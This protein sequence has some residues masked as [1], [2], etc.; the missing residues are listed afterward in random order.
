[1]EWLAKLCVKLFGRSGVSKETCAAI[2]RAN[3]TAHRY[4]E[5]CIEG[6]EK[7]TT[8]RFGELKH[9]MGEL[10]HDMQAGFTEVKQLIK[11]NH[12]K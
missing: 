4:L 11:D 9:D 5:D 2:Q 12:S 10:K 6:A 3:D 7:R 1:M 8:T